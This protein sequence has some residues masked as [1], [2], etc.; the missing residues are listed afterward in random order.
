MEIK[1][2]KL[3]ELSRHEL[4]KAQGGGGGA[5]WQVGCAIARFHNWVD[6]A[7]ARHV[8]TVASTDP[9]LLVD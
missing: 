5:N 7:T 1:S 3:V 9:S 2:N 6:R 4:I 8:E